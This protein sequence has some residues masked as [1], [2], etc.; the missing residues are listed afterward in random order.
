MNNKHDDGGPAYPRD[1]DPQMKIERHEGMTLLDKFAGQAIVSASNASL[2]IMKL[3]IKEIRFIDETAEPELRRIGTEHI[4]RTARDAYIIADQM[5]A[6]KRK[7]EA[8]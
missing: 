5:I 3:E 1:A 6:E 2:E 7:R 8:G 4:E